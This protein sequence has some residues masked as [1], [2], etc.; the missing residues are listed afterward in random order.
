MSQAAEEA[1]QAK[2]EEELRKQQK[3]LEDFERKMKGRGR[4]RPRKQREVVE[5]VG[6]CKKYWKYFL[7]AIVVLAVSVGVAVI[8]Q[9]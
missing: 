7:A 3:E 5:E 8:V 9:S 2:K 1:E 4:H 6:F